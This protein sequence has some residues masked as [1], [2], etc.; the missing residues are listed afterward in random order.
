MQ[1]CQQLLYRGTLVVLER[2]SS[3]YGVDSVPRNARTRVTSAADD[4]YIA[5]QH[6]R[7]R[8][9]TEAATGKQNVFIHR[10]SEIG[11]DKPF[12]L[13]V[14]TDRTSVKFSPDVIERQGGTSAAVPCT[15][16]RVDWV[17]ILFSDQCRLNFSHA[18]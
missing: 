2:L 15:F 18:R 4:R 11:R 13:I 5:L 16:R 1:A 12:N 17:F 3:V 6:L 14:G 7:N 10:L 9:L 8:G